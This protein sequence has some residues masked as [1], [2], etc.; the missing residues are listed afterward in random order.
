MEGVGLVWGVS[1][2][3]VV[4]K[5]SDEVSEYREDNEE[6]EVLVGEEDD[7]NEDKV[8]VP[9]NMTGGGTY[10]D[11][12]VRGTDWELAVAVGVD[13]ETETLAVGCGVGFVLGCGKLVLAGTGGGAGGAC[14]EAVTGLVAT[15]LVPNTPPADKVLILAF[16]H[17][18]CTP[19]P[20][21]NCSMMF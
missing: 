2:A 10:K 3:V 6:D 17:R 16:E 7:T 20:T 8:D 5:D 12:V 11:D 15:R 13:N 19:L 1:G 14:V 18:S 9:E 4:T 21:M